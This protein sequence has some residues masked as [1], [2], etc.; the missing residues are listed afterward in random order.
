MQKVGGDDVQLA[1]AV[2]AEDRQNVGGQLSQG[3][4][5]SAHQ[6]GD[7]RNQQQGSAT[8]AGEDDR[9]LFQARIA[10]AQQFLDG[11]TGGVS[12]GKQELAAVLEHL[13]QQV[14]ASKDD[15]KPDQFVSDEAR[16][17]HV[18]DDQGEERNHDRNTGESIDH[19]GQGTACFGGSAGHDHGPP[20]F[21]DMHQQG[22]DQR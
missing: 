7:Q 5:D 13:D 16:Q 12:G 14:E 8:G 17:R 20:R 15:E 2:T 4:T 19:T 6:Q 22:R 21:A 1:Q 11:F 3:R 9:N 18:A 10:N